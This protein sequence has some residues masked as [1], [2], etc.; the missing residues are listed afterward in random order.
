MHKIEQISSQLT[1]QCLAPL[2][3]AL[4]IFFSLTIVGCGGRQVT[5]TVVTPLEHQTIAVDESH[6]L[7]LAVLPFNPGLEDQSSQEESTLLPAVR[8]ADFSP[9]EWIIVPTT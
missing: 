5:S 7:D 9:S 1:Q 2:K 6:L 3:L 8:N 4:V